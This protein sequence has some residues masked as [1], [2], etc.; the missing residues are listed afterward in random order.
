[1]KHKVSLEI[2]TNK[3]GEIVEIEI[4]SHKSKSKKSADTK[5]NMPEYR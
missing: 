1:M 5:W 4:V 2:E 3:D